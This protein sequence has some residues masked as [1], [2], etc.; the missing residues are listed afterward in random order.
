M[1]KCAPEPQGCVRMCV[2]ERESGR[3]K[4]KVFVCA[5]AFET[6]NIVC[7]GRL[8]IHTYE[9][10]GKYLAYSLLWED[11]YTLVW[12][13]RRTVC[14]WDYL[15]LLYI[16]K[17]WQSW[18][19]KNVYTYVWKIWNTVCVRECVYLKYIRK[20]W[21]TV[22]CGKCVYIRIKDLAYSFRARVCISGILTK[23]MAYSLLWENVY[24]Y[25]WKIWRIVFVR[26]CVYLG[27]IRKIWHTVYCGRMCICMYERYGIRF[28]YES[29]YIWDTYERYGIQ[30]VMAQF[31]PE[32]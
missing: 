31:A 27:Y 23:D 24:M 13:F 19:W 7:S 16:R 28:A 10:S 2:R 4:E 20:I 30:F 8:C 11:M 5:H 29:V 18:Q 14:A 21:H 26:E 9:R 1:G 6:S 15:Y 32:P 17:I 25:V 22:C 12:K 3:E